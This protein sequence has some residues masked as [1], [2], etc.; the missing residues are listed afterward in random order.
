MGKEGF[1]AAS[2]ERF[3]SDGPPPDAFD[4]RCDDA[5]NMDAVEAL[6]PQQFGLKIQ[7]FCGFAASV[8]NAFLVF[9]GL[10]PK[11]CEGSSL[12]GL[13]RVVGAIL[14][15][16]PDLRV[17][18]ISRLEPEASSYSA[19]ELRPLEAPDVRTYLESHPDATTDL[20][21]PEVIEKLHERSE[22]L[23]MH[24]DRILR[25]LKVS[26]LA[27]VLDADLE[28]GLQ[29]LGTGQETPKA[30]VHAVSSLFRSEEKRSLRS[31]RLLK[32]L[33]VLP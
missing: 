17:V 32:V 21:E 3:R 11:V 10:H 1:L 19:I 22:G 9:D 30:I 25:A 6:F 5:E 33:T 29:S 13:T 27:S 12:E 20:R 31:F 2:I 14:D 18:L 26:S 24:L 23:P 7:A 28:E 15:Y 8:R 4:L 16:C